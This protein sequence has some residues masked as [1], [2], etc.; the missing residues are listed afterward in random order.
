MISVYRGKSSLWEYMFAG[1]LIGSLSKI[2]YRLRGI[3]FGGTWGMLCGAF[4]GGIHLT[5]MT[6]TGSRVQDSLKMKYMME[7]VSEY[8]L[9][10]KL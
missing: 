8:D 5:L 6:L 9:I 10:S 2:K 4:V 1:F 3:I 7:N